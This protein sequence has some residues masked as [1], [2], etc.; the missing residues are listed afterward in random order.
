MFRLFDVFKCIFELSMVC[1]LQ[2]AAPSA[3]ASTS[4]YINFEFLVLDEAWTC[5]FMPPIFGLDLLWKFV[6]VLVPVFE[7]SVPGKS[8]PSAS[9]VC[10]HDV[11]YSELPIICVVLGY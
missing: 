9:A 10:S 5:K 8:F 11:A 1:V 6:C 2:L 4:S 3:R 7:Y